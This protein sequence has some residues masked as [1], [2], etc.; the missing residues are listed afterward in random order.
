M[1]LR[2]QDKHF[3]WS[4]IAAVGVIL[5]WRGIWEGMYYILEEIFNLP[6]LADPWVFLFI[7]FAMLTFSG[8]IF[9]EFDPLGG[10]EKSTQR[11]IHF[12]H[13]HPKKDDFEIKYLDK[14][15]KKE[16]IFRADKLKHIEKSALVTEHPKGKQELFIPMHR[17][18]EVV[19]KGK[20]YWRL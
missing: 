12:V 18:T 13:S 8:I 20:T 2:E 11:M 15:L 7:G 16:H 17:V 19:Y 9:K 14:S 1:V 3:L 10:I 6:F 4:I 5:A